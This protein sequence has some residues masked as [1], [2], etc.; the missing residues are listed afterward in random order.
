MK[1]F[2]KLISLWPLAILMLVSLLTIAPFFNSG[3]FTMHDDTQVQ[4]VFEMKEAL[5]DGM[6]PVRWVPDLGYGYGYPIFNFYAPLPYYIG[7]FIALVGINILLATKIMIAGIIVFASFS[8]YLLAKEFWGKFGALFSGVLYLFAPYHGLNTY[9]RGDVGELYAYFFIPLIFYGIWKHY[10]TE[11]FNYLLIGSL[12]YAGLITSHNLSAMMVTP[13]IFLTILILFIIKR[14]ISLFALPLLGIILS[15]FYFIPALTEMNYTNVIKV[16]GEN[17]YKDHFVC[18]SQLWDSIWMYGGSIPGCIDGLSF[19]LG[20]IHIIGSIIAFALAFIF[21]KKDKQKSFVVFFSSLLLLI[22]VFFL[23]DVS[24]SVWKILPYIDYLQYPWRF[25]LLASFFSSFIGGAILF[26]ISQGFKN[27]KY[28]VFISLISMLLILSPVLVYLKLFVPQEYLSKS[29]QDYTNEEFITWNTSRI[30]D[31]YMPKDFR[32]PNTR[33][34]II[35]E[36][37]SSENIDLSNVSE[38]TNRLSADIEVAEDALVIVHIPYFPAWKYYI[39]GNPTK[40][41]EIDVGVSFPLQKGSYE[42]LAKFEQTLVER[43]ANALSISGV[44]IIVAG[45]IYKRKSRR[46]ARASGPEGKSDEKSKR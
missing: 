41:N 31:E 6:F 11:N 27:A 16:I 10:K 42:F 12:S 32:T 8:M 44:G 20:K 38:K 7:G 4:R 40:V 18:P 34:E 36:K 28:K 9:V 26:F 13:F 43:I 3:F 45:I 35:N 33:E 23:L 25:L 14:K 2:E 15:S 1:K 5:S 21:F 17:G 22:S 30:S 29:A 39:N 19:R 24:S 46:P 37:I